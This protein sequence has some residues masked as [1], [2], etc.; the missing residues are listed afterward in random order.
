SKVYELPPKRAGWCGTVNRVHV[1]SSI[2]V[3]SAEPTI[4]LS[5]VHGRF[6]ALGS[7]QVADPP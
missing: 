4:Q 3:G 6:F 5:R 1:G 2:L 7:Q